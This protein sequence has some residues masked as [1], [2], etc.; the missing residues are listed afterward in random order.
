MN[1]PADPHV[2]PRIL[3]ALGDPLR[4]RIVTAVSGSPAAATALAEQ[5]DAPVAE[6]RR[7]LDVLV[8]CDAV[9]PVDGPDVPAEHRRYRAMLRPLL[10]DAHWRAL[11]PERR[12]ALFD[13]TLSD[14]ATRIA[15]ARAVG[16]FGHVQTHV[17]LSRLMLDEQGWQEI[18]DLLAGVVEEA[19]EIEADCA[20]R[21]ARGGSEP[22]FGTCL[23]I[24]HFGRA[25]RRAPGREP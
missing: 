21:Q 9:E 25:E 14:I 3:E 16:G 18:S 19:M 12:Q 13:L 15:E 22:L 17:S 11:P 5:L 10:D 4:Q 23:A 8:R 20:D 2:D 24:L 7:H 1:R 6:I